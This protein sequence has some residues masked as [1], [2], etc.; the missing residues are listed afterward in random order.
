MAKFKCRN[1]CDYDGY[2]NLSW[3]A[4]AH[5]SLK[6]GSLCRAL[7]LT[8][9][10]R[11]LVGYYFFIMFWLIIYRNN[12]QSRYFPFFS[13]FE[14]VFFW[15]LEFSLQSSF[16]P[17]NSLIENQR[18]IYRNPCKKYCGHPTYSA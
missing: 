11:I 18:P 3:C 9:W 12:D 14:F 4:M 6:Q 8:E 15:A 5:D 2:V 7:A 13:T 17:S 10:V 1:S 16:T